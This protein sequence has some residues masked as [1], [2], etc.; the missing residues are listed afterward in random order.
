MQFSRSD[1]KKSP[2]KEL[3]LDYGE[4]RSRSTSKFWENRQDIPDFNT[5]AQTNEFN[6]KKRPQSNNSVKVRKSSGQ[7][8]NKS[9]KFG[10][11][12]S[13]M[14]STAGTSKP[15][16]GTIKSNLFIPHRLIG[17]NVF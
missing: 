10:D 5:I 17:R 15:L 7:G 6:I 3:L 16:V 2:S 14:G 1:S 4:K 11:S 8:L 13:K 9:G 12:T